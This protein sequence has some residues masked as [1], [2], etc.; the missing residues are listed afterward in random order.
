VT[1]KIDRVL[2]S[3]MDDVCTK[4]GQNQLKDV[5]SRVLTKMLRGKNLT[6]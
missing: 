1:L 5:D 2:E 3:P 6:R 4:F